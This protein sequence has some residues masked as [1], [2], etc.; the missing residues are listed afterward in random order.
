MGFPTIGQNTVIQG[1]GALHFALI[2]DAGAVAP[3]IIFAGGAEELSM[4][5]ELEE[6]TL[7]SPT[8]GPA[9][10]IA[11]HVTSQQLILS[12]NL[13][14]HRKENFERWLLATS[15]AAN[16]SS[17][18]AVTYEI[19]AVALDRY[20]DIGAIDATNLS[21]VVDESGGATLT[22]GTHY[23]YDAKSGLL[24]IKAGATEGDPILVTFDK[25]VKTINRMSLGQRPI[26]YVRAWYHNNL[27]TAA[28]SQY[29][30]YMFPKARMAPNGEMSMISDG[31]WVL[32]VQLTVIADSTNFPTS[33]YGY[34]ERVTG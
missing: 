20:Y 1:K 30:K 14:E 19:D 13:L 26:Q 15:A 32:P 7:E 17:G 28:P 27:F 33:P 6:E 24:H 22:A 12:C 3:A 21:V 34:M 23:V 16:Q 31:R 4:S 9:L 29:D 25:P 2:D 10:V 11:Q 18:T 5:W 8:E